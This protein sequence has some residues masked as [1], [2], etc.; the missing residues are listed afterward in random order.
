MDPR[1]FQRVKA[2]T[3]WAGPPAAFSF[4][5]MKQM[6]VCLRKWQLARSF[7][8]DHKGYPERPSEPAEVGKIVHDLL[9]RLFQ[10]AAVAGY[11]PLGSEEFAAVL[12]HVD[13]LG[14]ARSK[15]EAFA[16]EAARSPRSLGVRVSVSPR[17]VYNQVARAFREEYTRVLAE[18]PGWPPIPK[19]LASPAGPE[20]TPAD[21]LRALEAIGVLSEEA[22]RHPSLPVW[23]II[24]LLARREGRTA[25][26]DFKTGSS[27]PE[28]KEQIQ[29]YALLWWRSTGDLPVSVELRYGARSE[30]WPVSADDLSRLED[31]LSTRVVRYASGLS[32]HPAEA[33]IGAHCEGCSARPLCGDYWVGLAATGPKVPKERMDIELQV[34]SGT[35]TGFE[36][37]DP[38]G[39]RHTVVFDEEI[40]AFFGP[41]A[42]GE[43]LRILGATWDADS[44]ALRLT[45]G[46]EVF[47]P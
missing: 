9:S 45:R 17:D 1:D 33:K 42:S 35:R 6:G 10:R 46:T 31:D 18:A 19:L 44:G 25:V 14:T 12:D 34:V 37:R 29:L 30:G 3:S 24:D 2:P 36:G 5:S 26:I 8:G 43:R 16:R 23:G 22:V 7:Y 32:A 27:R 38:R 39:D 11:P 40:T 20:D 47:R 13:I 21:R 41:F 4:S 28:Y 15:L